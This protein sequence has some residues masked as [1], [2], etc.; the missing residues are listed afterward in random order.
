LLA[1]RNLSQAPWGMM[2]ASYRKY[3]GAVARL[4]LERFYVM[5]LSATDRPDTSEL[6]HKK[7]PSI[8]VVSDDPLLASTDDYGSQSGWL[9]FTRPLKQRMLPS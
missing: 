5:Q 7:E 2:V 6:L 3:R 9:S 4:S 8:Y 1:D